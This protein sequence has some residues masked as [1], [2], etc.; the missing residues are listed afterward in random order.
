M[1][2]FN[3]HKFSHTKNNAYLML[4]TF[5]NSLILK[6]FDR[7]SVLEEHFPIKTGH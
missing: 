4:I 1:E 6:Y 3:D 2:C 5:I 7:F